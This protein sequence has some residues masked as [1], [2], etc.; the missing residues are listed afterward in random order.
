M[1]PYYY[2]FYKLSCFLNKKGNNE[3]GSI[4]A[5]TILVCMNII[6]SY[7]KLFHLNEENSKGGYKTGILAICMTLFI[8]NS[9]LFLNKKRQKKITNHYKGETPRSKK[10]GSFLVI[11]YIVFTIVLAIFV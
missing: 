11:L 10:L 7:V 5:L 9:L 3:W 4:Y 6:V 8:T 1:N 2:L